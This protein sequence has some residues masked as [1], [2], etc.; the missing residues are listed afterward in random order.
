MSQQINN[1]FGSMLHVCEHVLVGPYIS[2][3]QL[4]VCESVMLYE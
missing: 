3:Y 1:T 2:L 4:L